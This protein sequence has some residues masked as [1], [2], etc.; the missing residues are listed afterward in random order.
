MNID[1]FSKN[2]KGFASDM[3]KD[4]EKECIEN[5]AEELKKLLRSG[6]AA[7]SVKK[8][9]NFFKKNNKL[10]A[11]GR[12]MSL[13]DPSKIA[14]GIVVV[15]NTIIIALTQDQNMWI[16]ADKIFGDNILAE[17]GIK[18]RQNEG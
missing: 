11:D 12:I 1:D 5:L 16:R 17:L 10:D 8:I 3:I 9:N 4:F 7:G 18:Y 15:D 2:I 14:D 13:S 6:K